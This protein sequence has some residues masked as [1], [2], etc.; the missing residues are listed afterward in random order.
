ML[1]K[2]QAQLYLRQTPNN[3]Q[4]IPPLVQITSVWTRM[5][6]AIAQGNPLMA[7]E[8]VSTVRSDGTFIMSHHS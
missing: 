3:R 1:Q 6:P 2:N 7:V 8:T 4:L 5:Q